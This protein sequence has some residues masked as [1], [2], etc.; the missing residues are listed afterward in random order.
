MARSR[1]RGKEK[2]T[3]AVQVGRCGWM[4]STRGKTTDPA[5]QLM[6]GAMGRKERIKDGSWGFGLAARK[7]S[8]FLR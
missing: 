1:E 6:W 3:A 5:N 7:W 8:H 2:I 4:R